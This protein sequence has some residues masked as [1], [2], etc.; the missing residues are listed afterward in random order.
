MFQCRHVRFW[1]T[2]RRASENVWCTQCISITISFMKY[3]FTHWINNSGAGNHARF[4]QQSRSQSDTPRRSRSSWPKVQ[5]RGKSM[6]STVVLCW[7]TF[8]YILGSTLPCPSS[9]T[10]M[11]H[12]HLCLVE[13]WDTWV[14]IHCDCYNTRCAVCHWQTLLCCETVTF[15]RICWQYCR[16]DQDVWARVYTLQKLSCGTLACI[17]G[18]RGTDIV[19]TGLA[20]AVTCD[21]VNNDIDSMA[22]MSKTLYQRLWTDQRQILPSWSNS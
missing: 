22:C 20:T 9:E 16:L 10:V 13:R 21:S 3:S 4:S 7:W 18:N 11:C 5:W 8:Q 14:H 2:T 19:S 12:L 15:K 17:T 6:Q 1:L